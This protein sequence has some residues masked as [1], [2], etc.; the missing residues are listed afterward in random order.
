MSE[1]RDE[2][3]FEVA[4]PACAVVVRV[5]SNEGGVLRGTARLVSTG[6]VIPFS[7]ASRLNEILMAAV[8]MPDDGASR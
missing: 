3:E 1:L 8:E 7:D 4:T 5:L 6:Q 2:A